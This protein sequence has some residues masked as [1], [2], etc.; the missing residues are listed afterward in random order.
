MKSAHVPTESEEN[1]RLMNAYALEQPAAGA[2]NLHPIW[3][4]ADVLVE[5]WRGE[6]PPDGVDGILMGMRIRRI[7]MV[8][9]KFIIEQCDAFGIK[10]HEF[11]LLMALRRIGDPYVLR[12]SDILKMYSVTSGTATYRLDQ[13]VK[14]DLAAREPDPKDRRGYLIRLTP[15]G[16]QSVDKILANLQ[17]QFND[18]MAP[19]SRIAGGLGALEAGLRLFEACLLAP[20]SH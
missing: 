1:T 8:I 12:P 6:L 9:D 19:F 7:G 10:H 15:H 16:K 13:L 18:R 11:I 5:Q 14:R 3:G 20:E 2:A 17:M 4:N